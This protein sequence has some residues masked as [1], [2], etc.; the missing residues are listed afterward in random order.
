LLVS[1]HKL[2]VLRKAG[3][4]EMWDVSCYSC[5]QVVIDSVSPDCQEKSIGTDKQF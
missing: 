1:P 4:A 3:D 2:R 5:V